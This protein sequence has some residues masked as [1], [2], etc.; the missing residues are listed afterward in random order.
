MSGHVE[1][2]AAYL[3][4]SWPALALGLLAGFIVGVLL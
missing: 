1:L 4:Q 2:I 3:R